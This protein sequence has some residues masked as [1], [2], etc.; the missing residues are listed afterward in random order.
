M[1]TAGAGLA[2]RGNPYWSCNRRRSPFPKGTSRGSPRR[3]SVQRHPPGNRCRW[4]TDAAARCRRRRTPDCRASD[5]WRS[6]NRS[7]SS[8]GRRWRRRRRPVR[9][10]R[11]RRPRVRRYRSRRLR[12]ARR[13]RPRQRPAAASGRHAAGTASRAGPRHPS[14]ARRSR[15]HRRRCRPWRSRPSRSR[16][17]PALP[18]LPGRR[19]SIPIHTRARWTRPDPPPK[20]RESSNLD[21]SASRPPEQGS[22]QRE[23][24]PLRPSGPPTPQEPETD[25]VMSVAHS[26]PTSSA[27]TAGATAC[28][29]SSTA[30][31][32]RVRPRTT[33]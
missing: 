18:P 27:T 7:S 23:G 14:H 4:C 29:G 3:L 30:C 28:C 1:V 16:Q 33:T 20:S 17:T 15:S 32:R 13:R 19:T 24:P 6:R 12:R 11:R 25:P 2:R 26:P 31:R 8:R 10:S 5:K 9:C 21:E 22:V